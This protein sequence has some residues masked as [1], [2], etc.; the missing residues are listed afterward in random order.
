MVLLNRVLELADDTAPVE[1]PPVSIEDGEEMIAYR[2]AERMFQTALHR[3]TWH[4]LSERE[5]QE[6]RR[7]VLASREWSSAVS[8]GRF[9]S[10]AC[11][12]AV[13]RLIEQ[14]RE[15]REQS[16]GEGENARRGNV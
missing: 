13:G 5:R 8:G 7:Q 6:V 16:S 15:M 14:A 11:C 3:R 1:L 2:E 12:D 9:F 10:Y 4:R